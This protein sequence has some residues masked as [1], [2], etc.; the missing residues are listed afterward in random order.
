M[1]ANAGRATPRNLGRAAVVAAFAAL[2]T[3]PA[4]AAWD[5]TQKIR[6][7]DSVGAEFAAAA[8]AESHVF[9]FYAPE[10]TKVSTLVK[11]LVKTSGLAAAVS[12]VD[13][14]GANVDLGAAGTPTAIKNFVIANRGNY[15]F[16]VVSTAGT[17]E[18]RLTTK[19]TWPKTFATQLTTALTYEFGAPAG[20]TVDISVKKAKGS[21]AAPTVSAVAGPSGALTI[22]AGALIRKLAIPVDGRYRV[23]VANAG[24]A[25]API[26]LVVKFTAP[27][28]ARVWAFGTATASP[29][30]DNAKRKLWESS[31]HAA[32]A[33]E[34]FAHWNNDIPAVIPTSCAKCHSG[35][36]YEDFL[37]VDGT[38]A[39]TVNNAAALGRVVDCAAC[40]N[41]GTANLT[42]VTFA[43]TGNLAPTAPLAPVTPT[44]ITGIGDESRCM[45]CHQGRESKYTLDSMISLAFV[46]GTTTPKTLLPIDVDA[47]DTSSSDGDGTIGFKNIHYF[48]AAATLYG[49]D[50]SVGYEY[51]GKAYEKKF[52][53]VEDYDSCIKCHDPHTLKVKISE[54]ATCH[55]IAPANV[56]DPTKYEDAI[57]DLHGA[58]M[59]G[60]ISDFDGDGNATEGLYEELVGTSDVLLKAIKEYAKDVNAAP[61]GY[62]GA[63]YPYFFADTNENGT[64]DTGEGG[65]AKWTARLVKAAFNYQMFKKDPG[66][67]AHNGKY[68]NELMYD[69]ITDLDA[70]ALVDVTVANGYT[71]NLAGMVRNDVGHFDTSADAYTDWADDTG[72]TSSCA[73]CHSLEGFR[74]RVKY[75]I[76]TTISQPTVAGML[77]ESCHVVGADFKTDPA[78]VYVDKVA[79]MTYP[80]TATSTQIT[81]VTINNNPTT[82]D[83]SFV[84]MTCH[85][86][87]Q[88]KISIDIYVAAATNPQ[89]LQFQHVHYFPA[90]ATQYST[91]AGVAYPW[92]GITDSTA[93]AFPVARKYAAPWTHYNANA[94]V[95][96]SSS[97]AN[98]GMPAEAQ[99]TF[100]HMQDGSHKFE[101]E[102]GTSCKLCHGN[103][104]IE[105]Y[106]AS[107]GGLT[108]LSIDFDGNA[109]T[110]ELVQEVQVFKDALYAKIQAYAARKAKPGIV[111]FEHQYSSPYWF[112]DQDLDGLPD[113]AVAPA[114]GYIRYS[115]MDKYMVYASHDL[116]MAYRDAGS[117]AHNPR[118]TMQ[119]LYD[120]IDYMD[121]EL[122][123][124]SPVNPTNGAPLVRPITN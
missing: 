101:P 82:P 78:R 73:R 56:T 35:A 29:A 108:S 96:Y 115:N 90:G 65:Y 3:V 18:Y 106:R 88:S 107:A 103:G 80:T 111:F 41:A 120:A 13:G 16:K 21:A 52:T 17:G 33:T 10:T 48:A 7:G 64:I 116:T 22:T 95:G 121:D 40:H 28:S 30:T 105:T 57:H 9:S 102:T 49:R 58:R 66:G 83:D 79:F 51:D 36:G 20:S 27:K 1:R 23:T 123:N 46:D 70:H 25:G 67:F 98:S 34:A 59:A 26:D 37:G 85:Q 60:T 117:W 124:G 99:C 54:C 112:R 86:G 42:T 71:V 11:P 61:I 31:K 93:A 92:S 104:T 12:L 69:S 89:T 62:D 8:G 94:W 24:T 77:C 53:H 43:A 14:A 114:T 45:V 100:C 6:L 118:Y 44:T 74:F 50:A 110:T 119:Y 75:G 38:A 15:G 4:G 122:W 87:R 76:D 91:K 81:G 2:M 97:V 55:D 5:G 84:C 19:A 39:G 109:A 47:V 68:L 63:V 72:V 113:P 32:L